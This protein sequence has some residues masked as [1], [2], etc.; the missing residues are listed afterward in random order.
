MILGYLY[1][2]LYNTI[3]F[4]LRMEN[5]NHEIAHISLSGALGIREVKRED[6]LRGNTFT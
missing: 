6:A 1:T 4:A 3:T 2:A 5:F